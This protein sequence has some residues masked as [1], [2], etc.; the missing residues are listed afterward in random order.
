M[1]VRLVCAL[2]LALSAFAIVAAAQPSRTD[3]D[4]ILRDRVA[5]SHPFRESYEG[6][7]VWEERTAVVWSIR[8]EADCV[9]ELDVAGVPWRPM[10]WT[11]T[12][13]PAPVEIVGMVGD[14]T[15]EKKRDGARLFMS[16]ELALRLPRL[17][18][19]LRAHG[20]SRVEVMSAYRREPL[21]SFHSSGLALDLSS[22]E[23]D[24]GVVSVEEHFVRTDDVATCAA[25][26]P[27][28]WQA[29]T[30]LEIACALG[31]SNDWST[32]LTPNYG[33]GHHDHLHVDA[34]PGDS[35][36]FLR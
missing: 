1:R 7:A 2:A 17:A 8:P 26:A 32:V 13:V 15:F 22:F 3:F 12:P 35:R 25:P 19:V 23:T 34:R 36:V 11:P 28:A 14:V 30:L 18:R 5:R 33:R 20:V 6:P 29:R 24:Q 21:S 27:S 16:C 9:G 10:V 4:R 31:R